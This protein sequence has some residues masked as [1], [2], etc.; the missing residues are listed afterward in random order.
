LLLLPPPF[1]AW[2]RYR[3]FETQRWSESDMSGGGE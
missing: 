2:W 1:I 3:R